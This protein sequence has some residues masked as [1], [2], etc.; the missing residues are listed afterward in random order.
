[1]DGFASLPRVGALFAEDFDLPETTPEPEVVDPVFSHGELAA[2]REAA[3]RDGYAA[4]LQKAAES[5]AAATR[6]AMTAIAEQFAAERNAAA[7]RADQ[8]AEAIARLL[9]DSLAVAFPDLCAQYGKCRGARRCACRASGTAAGT[10]DHR[11]CASAH[12]HG[13]GARDCAI[14]PDLTAHVQTVACDAMPPGD[15]RIAWRSGSATR[16]ATELW[17]QVASVLMP[18]GL[19]MTHAAIRETIDGD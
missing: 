17:R 6:Q 2:A 4:G 19:L 15:V 13:T 9:I 10:G 16:D 5:D 18:A 11:A 14:G 7:I 8:S 12:R 3:W 1:M